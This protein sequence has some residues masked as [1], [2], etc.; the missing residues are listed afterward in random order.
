MV[1]REL[2]VNFNQALDLKYLTPANAAWLVRIDSRNYSF[3]KRRYYFGLNTATQLPF[4]E[5]AL[6]LLK[7]IQMRQM[8][9]LCMYGYNTTLADDLQRFRFLDQHGLSPFVMEFQPIDDTLPPSVPHY[10]DT[11][12]DPLLKIRF[13]HNGKNFE[14]FLKWVSKKYI[15]E[16]GRLYLPLV[17]LIFKY[18]DRAFK[19]RY[20]ETLGGMRK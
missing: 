16:F 9:F 19:H 2:Q 5:R 1:Q 12:L 15:A 6:I 14:N 11:E 18:N 4:V 10:F 8:I 3:T 20:I 17:D 7:G 13:H